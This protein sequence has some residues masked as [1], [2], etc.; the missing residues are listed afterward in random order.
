MNTKIGIENGNTSFYNAKTALIKNAEQVRS[1]IPDLL[2]SADYENYEMS[3]VKTPYDEGVGFAET[4]HRKVG[5]N[6]NKNIPLI[7][8]GENI[9]FE[10]SGNNTKSKDSLSKNKNNI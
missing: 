1:P 8:E 9:T 2:A 7:I 3:H 10:K 6:S 5:M 4:L